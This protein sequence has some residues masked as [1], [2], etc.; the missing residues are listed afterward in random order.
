MPAISI[1]SKD[2]GSLGLNLK[3][4]LKAIS[5]GKG[6]K[7]DTIKS[8]KKKI[9]KKRVTRNNVGR[10]NTFNPFPS[11]NPRLNPY[12]YQGGGGGGFNNG[13][14]TRVEIRSEPQQDR[15]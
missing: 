13:S 9:R 2:L 10:I 15:L 5:N 1:D 4:L 3:D 6:S 7:N 8:K 11:Y 14:H 12:Q